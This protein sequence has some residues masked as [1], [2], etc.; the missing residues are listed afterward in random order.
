MTDLKSASHELLRSNADLDH[1]AVVASHDLQEPLGVVSL[2]LEILKLQYGSRFDDRA[3]EYMAHVSNGAMRMTEM[4]RGILACSRPENIAFERVAVDLPGILAEVRGNLAIRI[5]AA[6]AIITSDPLPTIP[7]HREQVTQLFQNLLGNAVK[8]C[9]DKR[10][11][12]IHIGVQGTEREWTFAITDNGIGIKEKD[13]EAIFQ[14][15]HRVHTDRIVKGFGIGL[16]TCRKIAERHGGRIWVTSTPGK[17][18]VF[19][20][21]IRA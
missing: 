2:Y 5:A 6:Q 15:F 20:F 8:Y 1:F 14:P 9:S 17:G 16:T 11:P 13:Y 18:S 7:A 12:R 10:R 4:I 3:R 19:S 21:T